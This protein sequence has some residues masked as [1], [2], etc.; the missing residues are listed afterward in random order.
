MAVGGQPPVDHVSTLAIVSDAAALAVRKLTRFECREVLGDF[1]DASGRTL[2]TVL[3][4]RGASATE[5]FASLKFLDGRS[6]RPCTSRLVL[7]AASPGSPYIAICKGN[8]ARMESRDPG[9]AA[10]AL[11]H[12]MLHALGLGENPPTSD[13]I[14]WRITERCGP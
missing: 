12:E 5:Y 7:A 14:T 1:R 11:I 8:F 13:E 6:V 10:N 3:G 9:L 4:E 2:A